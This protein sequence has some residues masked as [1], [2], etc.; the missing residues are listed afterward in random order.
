MKNLLEITNLSKVFKTRNND[1]YTALKGISFSLKQGEILGFLGPNGAGKT[2]TI[3][4]LLGL[5]KPTSGKIL[6]FGK[7][8]ATHRSE[9]LEKVTFAT[10]YAKLPARL[11]VRENL[12]LYGR[13][14]GLSSE[15]R[16]ERID[17]LIEF[18]GLKHLLDRLTGSLSAG[19]MTA[20]M[21][22]KAFMP[23]PQIVL[24]DEPTASLDP[25]I[26]QLV[27]AFIL[28]ERKKNNLSVLFTSHNMA[29]VEEICDRVLI[30]RKGEII[31]NSSPEQIAALISKTRVVLIMTDQMKDKA[32]QFGDEK[33]IIYALMPNAIQ[34]SIDE[35][36]VA[37][38]LIGLAQRGIEYTNISIE[39]P[40]LEDYF[41][42]I[43][44]EQKAKK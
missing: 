35:Q 19:Q 4:L 8:F 17:H 33:Q 42:Q 7:D 24:L 11:T 15:Q 5:M 16:T 34:Y 3:Q 12:E 43:A 2:T 36:A 9:I 31:A 32:A 44:R 37:A 10:A 40:T 27:Q 6:Y 13:L 28:E 23:Q 20:M 25:D 29:E 39:N 21:L 1:S 14:Y 30:L 18:F 22:V 38:L 26:A 41:L